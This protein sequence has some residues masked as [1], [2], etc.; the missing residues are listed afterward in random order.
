MESFKI[1][2]EEEIGA[3]YDKGKD[4]VVELFHET[5]SKFAERIQKLEDQIAKNSNNSG[6][7]PSSDGLKKKTRSLRHHSGKK[8]GGQPG[9]TG[10][11]RKFS[12]EPDHIETHPVNTCQHCH[13]DLEEVEPSR[14]ESRQVFDIPP[15]QVEVTEHRAEIKECPHCHQ[16]NRGTFPDQVSRYVQYGERIKAQMVYF[17]QQHHIP[18]ERT[19]EILKDLYGQRVSEGTIVEACK[20]T[21]RQIESVVQVIKAGLKSTQGAAHFDETGGRVDKKLWW[22]HVVSTRMLTYYAI[23]PNRGTKAIDAIGIL[24]AFKG[25]AV[26]D[27]YRSYFQYPDVK[28]A[29]CNA[30]HLRDLVFIQERYQQGWAF[31]M[32]QLLRKIKKAV[33]VLQGKQ[34]CLTSAQIAVFEERYD[35]I[36][37]A[38]YRE[39][40]LPEYLEE[41]P[42]KRGKP[43]QHPARNLLDHL[44]L[45][46]EETLAFMLDVQVPFDNNQAERDLR[47]MKLKQKI[48]GCFRS[49][50]GAQVF[51]QIRSYV[52]TAKKNDQSILEVL[53]L[54]LIGSPFVPPM[55]QD[56]IPA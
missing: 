32:D 54:A 34:E 39:N 55:L 27:G 20:R 8:S 9:H 7:P 45:R 11:T 4:A 23:H 19:A 6:K 48:S 2:S 42:K 44:K 56:F 29:L 24:P 49:E 51:C 16:I 10:S 15:V 38:G 43:K 12:A 25:T 52:S 36:I 30:H 17:N 5:F 46:Q 41:Q 18:L 47:M 31:E 1:P 3:A 53:R 35:A 50:E 26:H 33:D 22:L 37:E 13:C 21:A 40:P 28:N 14:Y